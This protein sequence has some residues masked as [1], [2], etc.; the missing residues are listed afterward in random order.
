MI[1]VIGNKQY[2]SWSLR[3]W[4]MMKHFGIPFEEKLVPLDLPTTHGEI[5]NFSPSGKV[6]ALI[7]GKITVWE[8]LAIAEYLNEKF[9]A[10]QMWPQNPE[11]RAMARAVAN[12]MHGGFQ[13]MRNHMPH[14]LKKKLTTFDAS[15]AQADIQRVKEI[16]T[17]CLTKFGGPFL[18]GEFSIADAMYAPVVNRF[19]SYAIPLDGVVAQYVKAMRTLPAHAEW[20]DQGEKETLRMPRYE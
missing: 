2:S 20:I 9:P 14:D 13:N 12:E 15:P 8:S 18:F 5:L 10:K 6:P 11:A 1:L 3:P 17:N 16:W 19:V 4:L 7:D